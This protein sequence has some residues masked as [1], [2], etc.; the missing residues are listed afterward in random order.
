M[1]PS[2]EQILEGRKEEE[3]YAHFCYYILP[4]VV[5]RSRWGYMLRISSRKFEWVASISDEALGLLLLENSWDRWTWE[6]GRTKEQ[7]RE[8]AQ[9]DQPECPPTKYSVKRGRKKVPRSSSGWTNEGIRRFRE[10]AEMTTKA[11]KEEEDK[12]KESG[13]NKERGFNEY[14]FKKIKEEYEVKQKSQEN[15][16]DASKEDTKMPEVAWLELND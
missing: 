12:L 5:G 3:A 2:L 16:E 1:L 11:R 10:L 4:Y 7:I 15:E 6:S 13:G 9:K 8:D 14:F